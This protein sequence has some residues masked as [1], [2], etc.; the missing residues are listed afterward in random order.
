MIIFRIYESMDLATNGQDGYP[1]IAPLNFVAL[2]G[3]I[4]FHCTPKGE[5]NNLIRNSGG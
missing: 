3:K 2:E 4:Y 1:Y 5:K